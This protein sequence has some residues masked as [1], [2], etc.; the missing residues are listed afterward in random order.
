MSCYHSFFK[1]IYLLFVKQNENELLQ[2]FYRLR[3]YIDYSLTMQ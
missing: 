2:A 1:H 3:H